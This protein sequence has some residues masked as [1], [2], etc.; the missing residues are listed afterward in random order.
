MI[1]ELKKE[2]LSAAVRTEGGELV[3]LKD[4]AGRE[5]I[6]EGDPAFWSGR[7]PILFPVVGALKDGR[8]D[9]GGRSFEMGRHGFARGMDFSPV[10]EGED[11][12]TL[13]LR[14]NEDTLARYPYPF[15]LRVT[16]RLL[17]DGFSTSFTVT[18]TGTAPMPFCIG[19]H[20]AIR[21]PE[22]ERMEDY[23]LL[24]NIPEQAA[25]HLLTP[26]GL[27]RHGQTEPM[28][29]ESGRLPLNYDV[30]AR[31]D[32][33]IFSLLRSDTVAL[34]HRQTGR[35]V[36]L[37]FGQFPM[38]AFWTK[39]GAPFLCMEP[40]QGCAAYDD[41]SGRFEDKPFCVTLEPGGVKCLT[42]S[43]HIV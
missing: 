4:Q 3:S 40:W 20:T 23:E 34:L 8:V 18:N 35:G 28:L 38:V 30:F 21:I 17:E 26:E 14:E 22:G 39:P 1:F 5:Y 31:L 7:N 36:Q 6:W 42:C 43:F 33:I 9:I 16:H 41:E 25:S 13:E 10:E 19:G 27:V 32:T 2:G 37:E 24:F 29:P 15:S 11:F 12:V